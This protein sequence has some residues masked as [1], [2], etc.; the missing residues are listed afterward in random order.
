MQM[1]RYRRKLD[2]LK[3]R[4]KLLREDLESTER[5]LGMCEDESDDLLKARVLIQEAALVTQQTLQ[6]H[7]SGIVTAA[8]QAVWKDSDLDFRVTFE[9]K[10]NRTVCLL[11]VGEGG[12]YN[13]PLDVRG[14]GLIDVASFA[15]RASFWSLDRTRPVMILD[16]PMKNLSPKL[17]P[18]VVEMIR[19]VSDKLGMQV[20]MVTHG[21]AFVDQADKVFEV[22]RAGIL[23]TVQEA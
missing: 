22:E 16:E 18:A 13:A 1:Q 9:T 19:M 23:T 7:L 21:A 8:L 14:G 12:V 4:R 17:K 2:E 11:E 6:L 5:L 10:N 15:L 20:I 3:A